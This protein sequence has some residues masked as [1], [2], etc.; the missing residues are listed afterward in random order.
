MHVGGL[1]ALH[2][3]LAQ[4]LQVRVRRVVG[5]GRCPPRGAAVLAGREDRGRGGGAHAAG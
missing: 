5:R 1:P 2:H 4:D 3:R